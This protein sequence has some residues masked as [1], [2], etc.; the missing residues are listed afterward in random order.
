MQS[1]RDQTD[2]AGNVRRGKGVSAG[3]Q[4]AGGLTAWCDF[5]LTRT[6][7]SGGRVKSLHRHDF[8]VSDFT[9]PLVLRE[10]KL[11]F[12]HRP[13]RSIKCFQFLR[14]EGDLEGLADIRPAG[15]ATEGLCRQVL[16][17]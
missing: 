2:D 12:E 1:G 9:L 16:L 15:T 13:C 4:I 11:E 6:P 17:S 3:I 10:M 7:P 5:I 14:L 8:H